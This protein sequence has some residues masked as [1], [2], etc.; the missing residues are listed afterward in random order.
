[1]F[2]KKKKKKKRERE[3]EREKESERNSIN[4]VVRFILKTCK[5]NGLSLESTKIYPPQF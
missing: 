1:M 4:F 3:R 2:Y 5:P